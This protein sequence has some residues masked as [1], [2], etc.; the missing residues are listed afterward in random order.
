MHGNYFADHGRRPWGA[1][2]PQHQRLAE[3][4]LTVDKPDGLHS[5][6]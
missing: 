1:V 2:M 4:R 6:A 5:T 3:G